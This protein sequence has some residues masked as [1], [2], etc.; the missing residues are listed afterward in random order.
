[1]IRG[2]RKFGRT[3]RWTL[4]ISAAALFHVALFWSVVLTRET[5]QVLRRNARQFT[6]IQY[7]D[8]R[9]T[10][11]SELLNQQMTL[12]DPRPL[13]LPTEWNVSNVS[14]LSDFTQEEVALF[15]DFAPMFE[16]EGGDYLD[17]FGN[18]PASFEQLAAAQVEFDFPLF[19][20]IGRKGHPLPAAQ[21]K[22]LEARLLDPRT[23]VTLRSAAIYKGVESL[24][25][26]WPDWQPAVVLATVRDSFLSGGV[27]VVRSAGYNDADQV[28]RGLT[29]D[30]VHGLGALEDGVYFVEFI[31]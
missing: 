11:R 1:M 23:G 15:P 13:L 27:S 7:F 8:A 25:R 22:S 26:N 18:A 4:A 24:G 6:E 20:G 31:P 2:R 16:L 10:E 3:L 12:F 9:T 21:A 19:V 28:L 14:R 5:K 29:R 30:F 17:D